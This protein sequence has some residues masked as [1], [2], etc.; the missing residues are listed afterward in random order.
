[1]CQ[2]FLH[3][4]YIDVVVLVAVYTT[5]KIWK[6]LVVTSSGRTKWHLVHLYRNI[7]HIRV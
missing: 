3:L 4:Q 5:D 1:M 6:C 2:V 7:S